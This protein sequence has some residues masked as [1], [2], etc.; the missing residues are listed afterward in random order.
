MHVH[1]QTGLQNQHDFASGATPR[2][3]ILPAVRAFSPM[4]D[5]LTCD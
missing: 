2:T 1:I 3:C 5:G 4:K